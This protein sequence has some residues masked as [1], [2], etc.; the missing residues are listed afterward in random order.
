MS[1]FL[2]QKALTKHLYFYFARNMNQEITAI[3][4]V[5]EFYNW[6]NSGSG[7]M[8]PCYCLLYLYFPSKHTDEYHPCPVV[9]CILG[10]VQYKKNIHIKLSRIE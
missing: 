4:D 1:V 7:L 5:S 9:D 6:Q 10:G 3:H 2:M 8:P